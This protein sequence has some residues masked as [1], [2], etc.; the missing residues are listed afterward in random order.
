M[1]SLLARFYDPTSGQITINN[2]HI[3]TQPPQSHR[4]RLALVQ[5]EPVLYQGSIRENVAMGLPNTTETTYIQI[6]QRQRVAIPRA[7]IRDPEILLLDEAASALDT[8]SERIVQIA[9]GGA[10]TSRKRRTV[11]VAHR[12]RTVRDADCIFV[13]QAGR[14]VDAGTHEELLERRGAL[15]FE[16]CRSQNLTFGLLGYVVG[17]KS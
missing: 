17:Y 6:E 15:F 14:I 8:E 9:L 7:L 11:A 4:R 16:M 13:F 2:Q 12:L 1:N 10:S 3:H 5:Q